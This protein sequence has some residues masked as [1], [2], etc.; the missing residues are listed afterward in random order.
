VLELEVGRLA[1][2]VAIAR[3]KQILRPEPA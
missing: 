2:V 3:R 1:D